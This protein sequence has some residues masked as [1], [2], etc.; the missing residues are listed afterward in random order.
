MRAAQWVEPER[1]DV[2]DVDEPAP[3]D[4]QV[5]VQVAECGICGSDLSSFKGGLG[6]RQGQVLG[7]EFSGLSSPPPASRASATVTASRCAR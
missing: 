5:L 6:T 7:H 2:A 1:L 3:G 4:G